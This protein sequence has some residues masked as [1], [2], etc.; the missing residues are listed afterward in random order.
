MGESRKAEITPANQKVG[1]GV[2]GRE[3]RREA[4]GVG[5]VRMGAETMTRSTDTG[6]GSLG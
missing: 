6:C 3:A 2:G 1:V 5:V 4:R